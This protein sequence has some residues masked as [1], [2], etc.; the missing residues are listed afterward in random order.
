MERGLERSRPDSPD[1]W[2][3]LPVRWVRADDGCKRAEM[4]EQGLRRNP[5]DS[6]DRGECRFGGQGEV[7]SLG[8]LS[9]SR[10]CG[11][12][13]FGAASCKGPASR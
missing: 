13:Y 2:D 11:V 9:V 7:A 3:T 5:R 8:A 12:V 1:A 10:A 4:I 6:W